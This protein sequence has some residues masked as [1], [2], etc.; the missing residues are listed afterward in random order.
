MKTHLLQT[1]K[2]DNYIPPPPSIGA[3]KCAKA[4]GRHVW[5]DRK[6]KT[7]QG[8]DAGGF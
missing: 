8:H 6:D 5:L 4:G 7:E 2:T 1:S 3:L